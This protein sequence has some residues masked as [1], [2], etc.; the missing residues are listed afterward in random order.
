VFIGVRGG[1]QAQS[2]FAVDSPAL[3]IIVGGMNVVWN[4]V[5]MAGYG[6]AAALIMSLALG[7]C[8]KIWN[9]LTPIDEWEELKKGNLAVAI[10]TAAV[11]I[12]FGM[13][14]SAAITPH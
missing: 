3:P 2:P 9:W 8:I 12:A 1:S 7:L 13:V 10:V 6:V 11:I 14:V 5:Y 4:F